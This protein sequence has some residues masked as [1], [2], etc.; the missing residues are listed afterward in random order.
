MSGLLLACSSCFQ[1]ITP[2][3]IFLLEIIIVSSSEGKFPF[4]NKG[5]VWGSPEDLIKKEKERDEK[6]LKISRDFQE[7]EYTPSSG[8]TRRMKLELLKV[9]DSDGKMYYTTIAENRN[10]VSLCKMVDKRDSNGT[11]YVSRDDY[12]I[13]FQVMFSSLSLLMN[14]IFLTTSGVHE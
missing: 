1:V 3:I 2:G 13:H 6:N 11:L 14:I 4:L 7:Y 12:K 8:N 10:L 5:K 9:K